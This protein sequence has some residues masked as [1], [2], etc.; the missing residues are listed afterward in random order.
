MG[1]LKVAGGVPALLRRATHADVEARAAAMTALAKIDPTN[2]LAH[3]LPLLDHESAD[4]RRSAVTA[5]GH[6]KARPAI[7]RLLTAFTDPPT[8]S[9]A[10][11]ALAQTPDVRA[12]DVY[13]AGLTEESASL[14][15]ASRRAL[16]AIRSEALPLL[17]TRVRGLLPVALRELRVVYAKDDAARRL[18]DAAPKAAE[19]EDYRG[20]ALNHPGDAEAG[21]ALFRDA[22]GLG[23]I[24]CHVVGDQGGR[25]GPDLTTVGAQFSRSELAESIL[26]PSKTVREGYQAVLV[27]TRDGELL[28][29]LFKGET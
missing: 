6:L 16:A 14:R 9:D 22:N 17:E 4:V 18:F 7:P 19:P 5:I 2:A 28:S 15:E 8:R 27:E 20:F 1:D 26:F 13:L 12:L 23:C 24:K 25:I 3:L 21:A 10:V 29:G 11:L